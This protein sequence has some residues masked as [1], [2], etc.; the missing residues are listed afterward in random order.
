MKNVLKFLLFIIYTLIIFLSNKLELLLYEFIINILVMII[1][2]INIQ[3]TI[4]NL[5]N[6]SIFITITMIANAF[7]VDWLYALFIGIKLILVCNITYSFSRV[8]SYT[9][10]AKVIEKL[11]IPLKIFGVNPTDIS[12]VICIAIAF[13][14]ILQDEFLQIKTAIQ[15]KGYTLKINNCGIIFKP[16]FISL[17]ERINEV[18]YSLKA[19]AYKE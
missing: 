19:K 17:F 2:R 14:P 16:F 9:E 8:L 6:I 3:K 5:L 13:M 7:I 4:K 1:L 11:F 18:S 10:F 12:L 15:V